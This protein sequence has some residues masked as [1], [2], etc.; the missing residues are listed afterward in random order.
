MSLTS[1]SYTLTSLNDASS[2]TL[3]LTMDAL[4][5]GNLTLSFYKNGTLYSGSVYVFAT[6]WDGSSW[7]T[8]GISGTLIGGNR[9]YS[10][11][12]VKAFDVHIYTNSS[13]S[14]LLTTKF[15]SYGETGEVGPP[16]TPGYLGLIVQG[17]TLTLKGYSPQGELDAPMGYIYIDEQR[18]SVPEYSH[19][20]TG[21]GQGYILFDPSSPTPVSYTCMTPTANGIVFKEYNSPHAI[22]NYPYILGQFLVD[23]TS[24]IM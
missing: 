17:T 6:S 8:S 4:N 9:V 21:S 24:H 2:Y 5:S 23:I 1:A 20:L 22:I 14:E 11:N 7:A 16:G 13:K 19:T 15:I 3:K 18:M 10:Y 12:D